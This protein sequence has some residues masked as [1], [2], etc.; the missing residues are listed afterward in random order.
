MVLSIHSF[1]YFGVSP[2]VISSASNG[3]ASKTFYKRL[4]HTLQLIQRDELIF[5]KD[6]IPSSIK[7]FPTCVSGELLDYVVAIISHQKTHSFATLTLETISRSTG[8]S[9]TIR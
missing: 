1:F 3:I 4:R 9:C 5:Y 2:L 6:L 8:T 7:L